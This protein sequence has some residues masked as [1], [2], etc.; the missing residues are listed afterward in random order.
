MV[1]RFIS[2][3]IRFIE[4]AL[5]KTVLDC[6]L[7]HLSPWCLYPFDDFEDNDIFESFRR[8]WITYINTSEN[9]VNQ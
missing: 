3:N 8:I 9:V 4:P 7:A 6:V 1:N 2:R 5:L